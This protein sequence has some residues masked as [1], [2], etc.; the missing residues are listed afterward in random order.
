[1]GGVGGGANGGAEDG[2]GLERTGGEERGG[3]G[4]S[5]YGLRFSRKGGDQGSSNASPRLGR[6]SS[7]PSSPSP[8]RPSLSRPLLLGQPLSPCRPATPSTPSSPR[9]E[10]AW[11]AP[12]LP[13]A[14]APS[15]RPG[16]A[17]SGCK[18]RCVSRAV[19]GSLG[20]VGRRWNAATPHRRPPRRQP[21]SAQ[22]APVSSTHLRA[23]AAATRLLISEPSASRPASASTPWHSATSAR[24]SG[25]IATDAMAR[26]PARRAE[27]GALL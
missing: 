14:F 5:V 12:I 24:F 3:E 10:P 1:M 4:S 2:R 17:W 15:P 6:A 19:R 20:P 11:P 8:W 23:C 7:L 22:R 27:S 16:S 21:V 18:P 13:E 25:V 26:A 9:T